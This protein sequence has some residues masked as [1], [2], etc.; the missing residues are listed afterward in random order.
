[1]RPDAARRSPTQPDHLVGQT[2][3]TA[4]ITSVA[5]RA[6]FAR[7]SK[8][9]RQKR[10]HCL[11]L[12][13]SADFLALQETHSTLGAAAVAKF[14]NSIA[15]W[16]SHGSQSIGGVGLLVKTAFLDKFGGASRA[17]WVETTPGRAA[18][19]RLDGSTGSLDIAVLYLPTGHASDERAAIRASVI[20]DLRPRDRAT[21]MLIGDWNFVREANDRLNLS[22]AEWSPGSDVEEHRDWAT[23]L[24]E[25][26]G[27]HEVFQPECTHRTSSSTSRLDRAYVNTHIADQLYRTWT[28]TALDWCSRLSHHRPIETARR[29]P[30][31]ETPRRRPIPTA[32]S[33]STGWAARVT[34][35]WQDLRRRDSLRD[36]AH[37]RLLLL[38]RAIGQICMEESA[39]GTTSSEATSAEDRL[40]VA[41]RC[42]RAAEE[43]RP[44]AVERAVRDFPDIARRLSIPELLRGA[45]A[46]IES[47][48]DII[49]QLARDEI[50]Q[51]VA[52]LH[53]ELPGMSDASAAAH[54]ESIAM[55]IRRLKPGGTAQLRAIR[56][57]DGSVTTD[58]E[59]IA[60]ALAQHW[61]LAFGRQD[62]DQDALS[63]WLREAAPTWE[64]SPLPRGSEFWHTTRADIAWAVRTASNSAPGPDGIPACL[65]KRLGSLAV[66]ALED[67]ATCLRSDSAVHDIR[68]AYQDDPDGTCSFNL[69]VVCCIP[70]KAG[71]MDPVLGAVHQAG[72]TRPLCLVDVSNRLLASAYKRRWEQGLGPWVS[73]PQRGFLPGRSMMLNVIELEAGALRTAAK[74]AQGMVVLVDF[75]AAFPSVAHDFLRGCL[76]G[77]GVPEEALA[78][79]RAFYADG[80]CS[81]SVAGGLWSGFAVGSGIRQGCPLSPLVFAACMD[82][83][84]RVLQ[85][86]LGGGCFIRAFADDVGIILDD[87]PKQLPILAAALEEFG[88]LSGMQVNLEKTIGIPLWGDSLEEARAVVSE[89][90]P[91][92]SQLP[93]SREATYLGCAI[94]PGKVGKEWDRAAARFQDRVSGWPWPELG[95]HFATFV[96]NVY[97]LPVLS[98]TAQIAD[99]DVA[100]G[101]LEKWALRRAA[102]GPGNWAMPEDLWQLD[103]NFGMPQAFGQ[104]ATL[105]QAAQLRLAA[106]EDRRLNRTS[107]ERM[108]LELRAEWNQ[109]QYMLRVARWAGWLHA[110]A[111]SV[112]ARNAWQ[113]HRKGITAERVVAA[114]TGQSPE[115][116]PAEAWEQARHSF[117]REVR[118]RVHSLHLDRIHMRVRDK[119]E[120]WKFPRAP[121]LPTPRV[122][123]DRV[124]QHVWA[125]GRL[126]PP[127]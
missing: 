29:T 72:N 79:L 31:Q 66:D 114:L 104:L 21:T 15:T 49:L 8:R 123:A 116:L 22:D 3:I 98:F 7:D 24:F 121:G 47:L 101:E 1:M 89:A 84:L 94:G 109:S 70:K 20:R 25:P 11:N 85:L 52:R 96:Y 48:K 59:Q 120:R 125:L 95:L 39:R 69:G 63:E 41:I 67:V 26:L 106:Y 19:L 68:E 16:W 80:A 38:K 32:P 5:E 33:R 57:P 75:R 87:V 56:K 97:A 9:H 117:Q 74:C 119:L 4:A 102:P 92:W 6:L 40:S 105:A 82:L 35:R 45:P 42:L 86:R 111:P 50:R 44:L 55:K 99:V 124:L 43:G 83:L 77:Y 91:S 90:A 53:S 93:L 110:S 58:P 107:L 65:W 36:T 112:L 127:R 122:L 113:L 54:R 17:T 61:R 62:I 118:R 27:F 71:D 81:I 10:A 103:R 28:C 126:V 108:T 46:A 14:P 78:A 64:R 2:S 13:R 115:A 100:V 51:D 60:D 76:R 18:I 73:E 12:L 23:A 30:G 37:R 34:L 88:R